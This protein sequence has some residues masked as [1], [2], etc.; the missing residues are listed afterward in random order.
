MNLKNIFMLLKGL[1]A[2]E[3]TIYFMQN[4]MPTAGQ[5]LAAFSFGICLP[6]N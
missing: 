1:C 4:I 2:N 6:S 5:N 3:L